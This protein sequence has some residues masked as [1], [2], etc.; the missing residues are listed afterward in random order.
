RDEQDDKQEMETAMGIHNLVLLLAY[1]GRVATGSRQNGSQVRPT[2]SWVEELSAIR[3]RSSRTR[4][5]G[6]VSW[7]RRE[8]RAHHKQGRRSCHSEFLENYPDWVFS[9]LKKNYLAAIFT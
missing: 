9:L 4:Q 2:F 3:I 6:N 1:G 8:G 5:S 7:R